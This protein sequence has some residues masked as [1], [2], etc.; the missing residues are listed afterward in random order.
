MDKSIISMWEVPQCLKEI[1]ERKKK[2]WRKWQDAKWMR[3]ICFIGPIVAILLF[4]SCCVPNIYSRAENTA[5]W[6]WCKLWPRRGVQ[7]RLTF[8]IIP[9]APPPPH[10]PAQKERRKIQTLIQR[11]TWKVPEKPSSH[12]EHCSPLAPLHLNHLCF[13]TGS[14]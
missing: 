12:E 7:I 13:K 8:S 10:H 9:L 3:V 14:R 5:L 1:K 2:S 4:F 11:N 6:K